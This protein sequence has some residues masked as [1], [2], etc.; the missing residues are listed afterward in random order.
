M[1]LSGD[2][3]HKS[4]LGET[5]LSTGTALLIQPNYWHAYFRCRN[6]ELV[7][8]C[9]PAAIVRS[10]WRNLLDERV[11]LL[12]RSGKGL[13]FAKL[14]AETIHSVQV[15][16]QTRR[17][18]CGA[19]ALVVWALDQFAMAIPESPSAIHPAVERALCALENESQSPW[20]A[21]G[22]AKEVGL[23][24]AY[25][26]RLFK[27]QVG[28]GPIG[29][30]NQLRLE[31][32]ASLL[33]HSDLNCSEVGLAVGYSDPSLFSRRFRTKFGLS[34]AAFRIRAKLS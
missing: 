19:L 25:L 32:A 15:I 21:T 20:T 8:F 23:D 5:P 16:E 11:R 24:R 2:G 9:F 33:R 28:T 6:L 30:V 7:N 13:Q 17:S 27:A 14:P 4:H 29:Y 31:H 34:P 12:L 1:I 22:L 18:S 26:S 10:E 3:I